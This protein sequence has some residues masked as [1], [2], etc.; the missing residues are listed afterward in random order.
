MVAIDLSMNNSFKA[1]NTLQLQKFHEQ[2]FKRFESNIFDTTRIWGKLFMVMPHY[3]CD[4]QS[5]FERLSPLGNYTFFSLERITYL[6]LVK[7]PGER[8][9]FLFTKILYK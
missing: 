7:G 3:K 8:H 5:I 4:S 1:H 2:I 9:V 6:S